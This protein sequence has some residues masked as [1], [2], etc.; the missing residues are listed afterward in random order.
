MTKEESVKLDNA[1]KAVKPIMLLLHRVDN[2]LGLNPHLHI[3]PSENEIVRQI[4]DSMF[5]DKDSPNFFYETFSHSWKFEETMERFKYNI[6]HNDQFLYDITQGYTG[7]EALASAELW[8]TVL[9]AREKFFLELKKTLE[10]L[11]EVIPS[12]QFPEIETKK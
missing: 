9:N 6:I 10:K 11:L 5:C 4:F 3:V 8:E 12:P 7:T 1:H 2:E